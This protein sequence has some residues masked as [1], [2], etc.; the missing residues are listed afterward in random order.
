[1]SI[2]VGNLSYQVTQETSMRFLQNTVQSNEFNFPRIEKRVASVALACG[3]E[4]R[5]LKKK[6][7]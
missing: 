5:L 4:L 2:Y 7:R 6:P 3:N 1:M